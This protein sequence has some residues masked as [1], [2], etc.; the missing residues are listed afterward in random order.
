MDST[1]A[2]TL[3]LLPPGFLYVQGPTVPTEP[4]YS[5]A[6]PDAPDTAIGEDIFSEKSWFSLV[7]VVLM[8]TVSFEEDVIGKTDP[9]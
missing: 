7:N 8:G 1:F 6:H 4:S 5:L 2:I 3:C 9:G